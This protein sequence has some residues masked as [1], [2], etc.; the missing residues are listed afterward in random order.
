MRA[1]SATLETLGERLN[2][3]ESQ[4]LAAQLPPGIGDYL[5]LAK[6]PQQFGLQ[7]FFDRVSEREGAGVDP[8]QA[9]HHART[10]VEVMQEAVTPGGIQHV[11]DQLPPEFAPLFDSGSQG[12]MYSR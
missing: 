4:H 5:R 3:R 10:V 11:R 6:Q 9:V 1:I 2:G 8:P 7:E 12:A